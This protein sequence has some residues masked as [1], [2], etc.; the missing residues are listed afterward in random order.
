M[1][2]ELH[3]LHLQVAYK[4]GKERS[5]GK[6]TKFL[7]EE[8]AQKAVEAHNNWEGRKHDVEAYPC[9][10]CEGWHIGRIMP[11][12]ILKWIIGS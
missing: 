12:E 5:C 6:K 1:D 11:I 7:T 8:K 4:V 10:F 2:E 9:P 3:S